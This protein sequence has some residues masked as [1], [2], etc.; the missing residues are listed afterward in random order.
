MNF[1]NKF[2]LYTLVATVLEL[3]IIDWLNSHFYE[4]VFNLGIIIPVMSTQVI[5]AY[6]YTKERSKAKWGKRTVGLFFCL[7]IILF[8]I[9]KP[10]YTFDQAKQ[11][12]YENKDVSTIDEY[13]EKESYRNTVP[14]HTEEWRFFIDYR[15]Y[16][17]KAEERFFLVHPRTGEVIEM[18]QPYWH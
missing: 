6:I 17:F 18:K 11:L 14:I 16:H 4:G 9:G 15:D 3:V 8:F 2:F 7:S 10:T 13:K 1:S 5:V 12:I